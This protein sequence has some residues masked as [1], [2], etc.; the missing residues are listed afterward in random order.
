LQYLNLGCGNRYHPDWINI[1][2]APQGDGVIAHD[3][4]QGIP[5]PNDVCDVVYHSDVLEHIRRSDALPFMQECYR[6]LKP[7][8]ILRIAVP[9]LEEIC[10]VYLKKLDAVV[11][12]DAASADDYEWILLEMYDQTVREQSGGGMWIYL[13]Q[14]P[15]PN[16]EFVYRRIGEEGRQ[17][18]RAMRT[19]QANS[20]ER[21]RAKC[22]RDLVQSF[23][24]FLGL[25][26]KRLLEFMLGPNDTRALEIGRF[27]LGGQ[28]HHWMYDRHS[29]AKLILAAGFRH[30]TIQSATRSQIPQWSKFNLDTLD[31][32]TVIKPDSFFMEAVKPSGEK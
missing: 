11:T 8:G 19:S 13:E 26:R 10:R 31:D 22:L 29:L 15:I 2:I 6:V 4:S 27:R 17:I 16:E 30:P 20:L 9:D 5:L 3:L 7:G 23:R 24:K 1:D 14:N 21:I 32:R 28:V 12:G 25:L 18:V